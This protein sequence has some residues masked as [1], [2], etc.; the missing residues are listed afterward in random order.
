MKKNKGNITK[1][2]SCALLV[3]LK[4][5]WFLNI[6]YFLNY[7]KFHEHLTGKEMR[8][9]R[10]KDTKCTIIDDILYKKGLDGTFLRCVDKDR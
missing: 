8:K 7:G 1:E 9:L 3:C 4:D 2:D 6:A 5:N 10:L